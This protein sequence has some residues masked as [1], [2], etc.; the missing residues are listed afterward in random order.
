M[1]ISED[2]KR[3]TTVRYRQATDADMPAMADLRHR[4]GWKGGATQERML[5]YFRG[6]HHP[7]LA[8]AERAIFVAEAEDIV[9]FIAGHLTARFGC[10]GELQWLL[11]GPEIRGTGVADALWSLLKA[12]FVRQGASSVC[13]NVEPDN[14]H[15]QRCYLRQGA[16][17][18]SSHWMIWRDV[19]E[20]I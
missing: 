8:R 3:M 11:V 14:V 10:D 2:A 4:A 1:D 13:V 20:L 15:A 7:Q 17:P 12:W 16:Q 19:N 5:S 9:A 18:H 6:E